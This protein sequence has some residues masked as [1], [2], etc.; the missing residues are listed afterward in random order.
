MSDTKHDS[1]SSSYT[2]SMDRTVSRTP[3]ES[4][5]GENDYDIEMPGFYSSSEV[6]ETRHSPELLRYF[7]TEITDN[8]DFD[9]MKVWQNDRNV[10]SSTDYLNREDEVLL[11]MTTNAVD[12][13]QMGISRIQ[14]LDPVA[15]ASATPAGKEINYDRQSKKS[16]SLS[17]RDS[18]Y[19]VDDMHY[20][21]G[22]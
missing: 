9:E 19:D 22:G 18:G 21:E 11:E 13:H 5:L 10:E 2:V 15:M 1:S 4:S 3:P 14:G 6:H 17:T 20:T 7:D 8:D 16:N 12:V